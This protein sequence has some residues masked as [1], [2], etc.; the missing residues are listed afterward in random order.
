VSQPNDGERK[1]PLSAESEQS[2][3]DSTENPKLTLLAEE[4]EV[5]KETVETGRLRV[6]KQTRT[7]EAFVDESLVSEQA[8]VETIPVGRQIF[9]MPSVRHEGDTIIVPIVEEV[10]HT[11]R[12][13]ILKEEVKITRRRKTEQFQDRVTL[14]YQ[15]AVITRVQSATEPADAASANETKSSDSRE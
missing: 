12:R 11:E 4:L 15:E 7:R 1:L 14:R 10:L 8:E 5:R 6:S 3:A 2:S 13:L 9:E